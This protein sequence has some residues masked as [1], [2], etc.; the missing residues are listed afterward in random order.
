MEMSDR[1]YR[2]AETAVIANLAEYMEIN[3]LEPEALAEFQERV[4]PVYQQ[5]IE[6]GHFTAEDVEAARAAAQSCS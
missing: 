5:M 4:E 3:T 2:E 6:A 1:L